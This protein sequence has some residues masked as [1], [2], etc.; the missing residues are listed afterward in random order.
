MSAG[1]FGPAINGQYRL[2]GLPSP[3]TH[4]KR[5][6][7]MSEGFLRDKAEYHGGN[8]SRAK[9]DD[10]A[11][12]LSEVH[13][14]ADISAARDRSLEGELLPQPSF[15]A[16]Q[17]MFNAVSKSFLNGKSEWVLAELSNAARAGAYSP[18]FIA[19]VYLHYAIMD[20]ITYDF[21]VDDL[22]ESERSGNALVETLDAARRIDLAALDSQEVASWSVETKKK[23]AN[24][25]L[26]ALRDYGV[27]EGGKHKRLKRPELP[28]SVVGHILRLLYE[29]GARGNQ[30]LRDSVWRL[31]FVSEHDVAGLISR[32]A[33]QKHFSFERSGDVVVFQAPAEWECSDE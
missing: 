25:M 20:P 18:D 22:F 31:F 5:G 10:L 27:L 21:V 19:L 11:R 12:I 9:L 8:T 23:L 32:L 7:D 2:G 30:L 29:S 33:Q 6:R 16:R 17:R 26:S 14:A 15:K 4:N 28:M 13:S 3:R 24:N 1:A